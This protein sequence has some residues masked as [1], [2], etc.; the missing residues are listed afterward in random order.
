MSSKRTKFKLLGVLFVVLAGAAAVS[1][2]YYWQMAHLQTP[3]SLIHMPGKSWKTYTNTE[4]GF[5]LS[6]DKDYAFDTSGNQ[7]NFFKNPGKS[8]VSASIPQSFYPKTN[9]GSADLTVAVQLKS[10][11]SSCSAAAKT[12][13][14]NGTTFHVSEEDGAAAGTHYQTKIYRVFRNQNCFEVSLTIGIANIGNFEPGAVSEVDANDVWGRLDQM[15]KTFKF[16]DPPST[17]NWKVYSNAGYEFKY[18][19]NWSAFTNKFNAKSAIFGPNASNVSGTGG[20]EI[21]GQ[22]KTG[23]T[24][25]SFVKEFNAGIEQGSVSETEAL[26]NN[27]KVIVSILPKAGMNQSETKSVAFQNFNDVVDVFIMYGTESN[28]RSETLKIFDQILSTF[29]FTKFT[30]PGTSD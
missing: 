21:I 16:T 14:V 13:E 3:D 27:Q 24:L 18:P 5:Q 26:I 4:F 9:F 23:Q 19:Q 20:V 1:L 12:A 30:G 8:L 15:L 7:A 22:L 6:Y 2:I 25:K 29:K 17:A 28:D 11:E 10:V